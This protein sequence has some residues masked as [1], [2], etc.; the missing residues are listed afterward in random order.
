MAR[1]FVFF[2]IFTLDIPFIRCTD[3]LL[4]VARLP[5]VIA[6]CVDLRDEVFTIYSLDY[7]SLQYPFNQH[8]L[9]T[10][11]EFRAKQKTFERCLRLE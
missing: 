7:V 8:H 6:C 1:C 5:A 11:S 10:K 2:V 4:Y 3:E 9:F